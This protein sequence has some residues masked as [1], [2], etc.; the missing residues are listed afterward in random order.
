MFKIEKCYHVPYPRYSGFRTL[1]L[2]GYEKPIALSDQGLDLFQ[3]KYTPYSRG[4][5]CLYSGR[6]RGIVPLAKA[7]CT[8]RTRQTSC[9]TYLAASL[10]VVRC[11][12]VVVPVSPHLY[13]STYTVGPPVHWEILK[14]T[15]GTYLTLH[16]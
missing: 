4:F 5:I 13:N 8:L 12:E 1:F 11:H 6:S 7:R 3:R 15:V 9:L 2:V 10:G 16:M 14:R